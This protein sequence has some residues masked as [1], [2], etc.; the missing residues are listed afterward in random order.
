MGRSK[1]VLD[2][3]KL[4]ILGLTMMIASTGLVDILG[5]FKAIGVVLWANIG[6][7][8]ISWILIIFGLYKIQGIRSEYKK[9]FFIAIA[10][11]IFLVGGGFFILREYR[12]FGTAGFISLQ[13]M[14]FKYLSELCFLA[15]MYL[16]IL[17]LCQI[18]AKN[19][20]KMDYKKK[21]GNVRIFI[22]GILLA[23]MFVPFGYIFGKPF[24]YVLTIVFA[25][26]SIVLKLLILRFISQSYLKVRG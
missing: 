20:I 15:I 5:V 17:G 13:G 23:T 10:G 14:F 18:M 1:N 16:L 8:L 3:T 2:N 9:A 24:N 11:M 22:I 21:I 19:Q 7:H 12:A 26:G 6:I 25:G 4:I